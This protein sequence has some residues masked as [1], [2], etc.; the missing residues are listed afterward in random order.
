MLDKKVLLFFFFYNETVAFVY[1]IFNIQ[2]WII[3]TDYKMSVVFVQEK[4]KCRKSQFSLPKIKMFYLISGH[5]NAGNIIF[6]DLIN[7]FRAINPLCQLQIEIMSVCIKFFLFDQSFL[8]FSYQT[9]LC[10]CL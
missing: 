5:Y 6:N 3:Q 9:I 10:S 8:L 4:Q 2:T 7:I 1:V